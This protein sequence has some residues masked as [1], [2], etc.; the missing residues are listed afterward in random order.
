M[1]CPHF[2]FLLCKIFLN[3]TNSSLMIVKIFMYDA[4]GLVRAVGKFRMT[5]SFVL[6][7]FFVYEEALLSSKEF[8]WPSDINGYLST[9][10]NNLENAKC[11]K[12]FKISKKL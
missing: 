5:I 3:S 10:A 4:L 12:I 1:E 6:L 11:Q 9:G 2:Y 7:I 8:C